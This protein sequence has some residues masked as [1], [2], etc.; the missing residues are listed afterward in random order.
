MAMVTIDLVAP[1]TPDPEDDPEFAYLTTT[2]RQ[3][4]SPH[5]VEL[6]YRRIG[7]TVWFIAGQRSD[8]VAN[9][10]ARPD[11][12]VR[13]GDDELAGTGRVEAGDAGGAGEARRALAARYQGWTPGRPLSGWATDGTV[14]A[15]DLS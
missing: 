3:T 13:I 2:G 10:V 4:G 11:V 12:T 6:W 5:V 15:V 9:L 8:W 1:T 14:V 7:D